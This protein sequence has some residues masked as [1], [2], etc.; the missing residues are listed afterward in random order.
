MIPDELTL[1]FESLKRT[2]L[3]EITKDLGP[4]KFGSARFSCRI[5]V[6]QPNAEGLPASVEVEAQISLGFPLGKV[7]FVSHDGHLDGFPHQTVSATNGGELCLRSQSEYPWDPVQRLQAYVRSAI[8]WVGDAAHQRLLVADQP[9]ELPDFRRED[10]YGP[11]VL[12]SESADSLPVWTPQIGKFGAAELATHANG[13]D[14]VVVRFSREGNTIFAPSFSPSFLDGSTRSPCRWLLLPSLIYKRHRRARTFGEMS[15]MCDR[16]GVDLWSVLRAATKKGS[17][18]GQ[19]YLLVGAPIPR[20]V[21]GP[22]VEVH[23]QPISIPEKTSSRAANAT[24]R[25]LGAEEDVAPT[26]FKYAL[27]ESEV[28]WAE[29]VNVGGTRMTIRGVLDEGTRARRVCVLGCGALGSLVVEHLVRGGVRHIAVFDDERI[30]LQNLTRHTLTARDLGA[31][32]A[33]A[34]ARRLNGMFPDTVILAFP[35]R[36]P[37]GEGSKILMAAREAVDTADVL[38]DCTTSEAAFR[39]ASRLGRDR[40]KLVLHL[41]INAHATML[42]LC[43]SGKHVSCARVADLLFADVGARDCPFGRDEY[44]PAD[45]HIEP[46]AGCWD[47]TF[48]AKGYDVAALVAAGVPIV[49]RLLAGRRASKGLAVVLRRVEIGEEVHSV[50]LV[51]VSLA[52]SYR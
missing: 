32:K 43:C 33:V 22:L 1:A 51:E 27:R 4:G 42:T 19:H 39:W 18:R 17:L 44:D 23:W 45:P 52:R 3:V 6:P 15:E 14:L 12:F 34:V 8:E 37:F 29:A 25:T 40:G 20:V 48:P 2:G 46:G 24:I 7:S 47:A 36:V 13:Q 41:F 21:G 38:V 16:V 49:E 35:F 11:R 31:L 28:P 30:E 5:P 50:P 9:W 10:G 26:R